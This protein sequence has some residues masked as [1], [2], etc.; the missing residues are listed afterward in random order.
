[1]YIE[2]LL[3]N[4]NVVQAGLQLLL[5][6]Y[7]CI[8]GN[9]SG[10]HHRFIIPTILIIMG[11]VWCG[12]LYFFSKRVDLYLKV[13]NLVGGSSTSNMAIWSYVGLG[14]SALNM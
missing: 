1:M 9:R 4:I 14:L 7:I 12:P 2:R 5:G 8:T 3:T 11:G 13:Q 10:I 6:L